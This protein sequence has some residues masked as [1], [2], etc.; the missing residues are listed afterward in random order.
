MTD[1]APSAVPQAQQT[2]ASK[3]WLLVL[4]V[5]GYAWLFPWSEQI[6]NPNEMVRVYMARAIAEHG[7]YV[8]GRREVVQGQLRDSGPIY[9]A[10]GYVNDKA[11]TCD[12]PAAPR[13]ACNGSLYAGKAPGISQLGA[14]PLWLQLRLWQLAGQ[15]T[16]SKAA[17][18][19]WLRLWTAVLPSI[20]AWGWLLSRLPRRLDRPEIGVAAVLAGAFGSLSLTYGQMFAGHQLSGLALLLAFAALQRA[21]AVG[22][23]R[24]L[25]VAG[26]GA[27]A[28]PWIEFP[29]GPAGIALLLWAVLRRRAWADLASLAGGAA[30]PALALGHFNGRAFGAPWK[31]P[32]GFLENPDFVRDIA[33]GVF[34]IHLPNAE[35][36]AGSLLS[37]F[38]GLYFWAPWVALAWL[39]VAAL[40]RRYAEP[41]ATEP[42]GGFWFSRRA[43]ALVAWG[44]VAYFVAFQ[45]SHSLWR[46]GWVVGPRY[47]TALVPFAAIATAHGLDALSGRVQRAAVMLLAVSAG[48]AIVVTG[49]ATAVCQGFPFEVYNPLAEVVGPLLRHGW[50]WSSPLYWLGL[51]LLPAALPWFAALAAAL[52]QL[53]WSCASAVSDA[54]PRRRV[55]IAAATALIS[56]AWV[57]ALWA[58]PPRRS[59]QEIEMTN[60][61]LTSTWWPSAPRG[62]RPLANSPR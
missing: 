6:N 26:F 32:Y 38:T 61:F 44:V 21:G 20:L 45:C 51:P 30:I 29:A 53:L 40:R 18:V 1:P 57:A 12:D 47:I 60:T 16:P 25:A 4:L 50:V 19:W 3:R 54:A 28:A 9:S 55:V 52:G 46:G 37:P 42:V 7:T 35:K 33:P 24:W 62:P 23:R 13:P 39:G 34:G 31:L 48:V 56:A 10:W 11:L 49:A 58:I 41:A 8:I 5:I 27:A 2:V 59:S 36:L 22:N 17:M 43:E 14:A 15:G